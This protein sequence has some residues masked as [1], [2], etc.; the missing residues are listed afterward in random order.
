MPHHLFTQ[1]LY[2][3]PILVP[4]FRNKLQTFVSSFFSQNFVFY[5]PLSIDSKCNETYN[6]VTLKKVICGKKLNVLT[7]VESKREISLSQHH[8][9]GS[10]PNCVH[11]S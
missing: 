3:N 8:M 6:K 4:H 11:L 1:R 5:K 2:S 9:Q 7:V 10:L